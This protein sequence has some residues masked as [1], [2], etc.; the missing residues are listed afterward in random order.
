MWIHDPIPGRRSWRSI[1]LAVNHKASGGNADHRST[2]NDK[3]QAPHCVVNCQTNSHA[4]RKGAREGKSTEAHGDIPFNNPS[5]DYWEPRLLPLTLLLQ[6]EEKIG[7]TFDFAPG[8]IHTEPSNLG[9]IVVVSPN[10]EPRS[11]RFSGNPSASVMTAP[12]S[13]SA[14]SA[15]V[16]TIWHRVRVFRCGMQPRIFLPRGHATAFS[17]QHPHNCKISLFMS[18]PRAIRVQ[19][20]RSSFSSMALIFWASTS[21]PQ[22]S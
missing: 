22:P 10:A 1:F 5:S 11:G 12:L 6:R 18:L 14:V 17:R 9:H 13:S 16:E 19:C 15:E 2:Q 3:C 8:K 7:E 21:W 4:S 20:F